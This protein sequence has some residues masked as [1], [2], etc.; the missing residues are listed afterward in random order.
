MV[1][2]IC[3]HSVQCSI[4]FAAFIYI[5][6]WINKK[7]TTDVLEEQ[8]EAPFEFDFGYTH[9][10]CSNQLIHP[11][12]CTAQE[13]SVDSRNSILLLY[14]TQMAIFYRDNQCYYLSIFFCKTP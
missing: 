6:C 4:T 14:Y 2:S 9:T 10:N 13:E 11:I 7:K 8:K 5:S 3:S 12:L 1:S